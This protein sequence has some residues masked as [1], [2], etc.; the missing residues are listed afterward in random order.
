MSFDD[1]IRKALD[2]ALNG[3]RTHLEADLRALMNEFNLA[4]D[5]TLVIP[6]EYLEVVITRKR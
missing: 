2:R 5:G 1:Q 6:G 4:K 3:V